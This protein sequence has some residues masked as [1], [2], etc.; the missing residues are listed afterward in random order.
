MQEFIRRAPEL[1][2]SILKQAGIL[3]EI[4][5]LYQTPLAKA[6]GGGISK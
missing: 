1:V 2:E 4:R 6:E 5:G 3:S